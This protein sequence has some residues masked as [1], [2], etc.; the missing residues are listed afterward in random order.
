MEDSSNRMSCQIIL[1]PIERILM[2]T[3]KTFFPE[4]IFIR[5][6]YLSQPIRMKHPQKKHTFIDISKITD[7]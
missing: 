1:N 6:R 7:F 3:N 5:I 2:N 4:N